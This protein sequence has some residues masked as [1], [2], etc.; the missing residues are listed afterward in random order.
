MYLP[1][2]VFAPLQAGDPPLVGGYRVLARLGA[3][4]MGRVLLAT[5]Q[6][7][8]RL[9]IKVVRP[10]LAGDP[11]FRR[12]FQEEVKAAQR[13]RGSR[14][15]QVVDAHPGASTPWLAT[16]YVPGPSLAQAVTAHGPMP[17]ATLRVLF[18]G[19]AEG[20]EAVHAAG[21]I[22]YDLKPSNVLLG[23]DGP[24]VIDAGIA[25]AAD[26]SPAAR[27]GSPRFMTPEQ[28]LD[29]DPTPAMDVFALGSVLH[30]A[31][32]GRTPFGDGPSGLAGL[33]GPDGPDVLLRIAHEEPNLDGCPDDL[34]P[35]IERCLAKDPSA[36]PAPSGI[37]TALG[38]EDDVSA[39]NWLPADV[40]SVLPAYAGEPPRP[41]PPPGMTPTTPYTSYMPSGTAPF[42]ARRIAARVPVAEP[43]GTSWDLEAPPRSTWPGSS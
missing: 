12:R 26:A 39:P 1:H 24:V 20:L 31:A 22:H 19:I 14:V 38:F 2:Q 5:A 42:G 23:A 33:A 10:E 8:R 35:L 11:G 21:M 18:A 29:H 16:A 30:F 37:R 3:G 25:R 43:R 36:R 40:A 41:V 9:A 6:S 34:R 4:G 15:A 13:V 27:A 7:G 32:T 17:W 28:A